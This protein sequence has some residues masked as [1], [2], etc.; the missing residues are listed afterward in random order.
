M[1]PR[2][3]PNLAAL[4]EVGVMF[5]PAIP[6]YLWIWPNLEALKMIFSR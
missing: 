6:A 4:L 5:L 3:H 2:M 1:K